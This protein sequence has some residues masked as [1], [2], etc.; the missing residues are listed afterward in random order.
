MRDLMR[1]YDRF[2]GAGRDWHDPVVVTRNQPSVYKDRCGC[3]FLVPANA[4]QKHYENSF[5]HRWIA[6]EVSEKRMENNYGSYG[7]E[8]KIHRRAVGISDD[9]KNELRVGPRN[10]IV[11]IKVR[12][13]PE[14][15]W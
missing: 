9:L 4:I 1:P 6:W 2:E 14:P 11:Y 7:Y 13:H 12:S 10:F 5:G 3:K 15:P 8:K